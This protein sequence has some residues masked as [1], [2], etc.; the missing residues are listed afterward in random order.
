V[1]LAHHLALDDHRIRRHQRPRLV[2]VR[3][4]E[5]VEAA[6]PVFRARERAG[7]RQLPGLGE[8]L[9]VGEVALEHLVA[10]VPG[11]HFGR[12]RLQNDQH[13]APHAS[14]VCAQRFGERGVV[15]RGDGG[16]AGLREGTA[17]TGDQEHGGENTDS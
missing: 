11:G 16:A 6:P 12:A 15:A 2:D 8:A 14:L 4:R 1:E 5:Q 10:L 3:H 17:G 7:H 9:D 13:V